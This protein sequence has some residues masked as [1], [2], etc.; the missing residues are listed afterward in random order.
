MKER[1]HARI[2][3]EPERW[4]AILFVYENANCVLFCFVWKGIGMGLFKCVIYIKKKK[5]VG[6]VWLLPH[7]AFNKSAP[8][9]T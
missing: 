4:N 7:P 5:M 3:A 8:A 2:A 9:N 1:E 6:L